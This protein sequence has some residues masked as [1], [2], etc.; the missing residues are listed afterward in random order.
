MPNE[1]LGN[2][3]QRSGADFLFFQGLADD[4]FIYSSANLLQ[5]AGVGVSEFKLMIRINIFL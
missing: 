1:A 4:D 2:I 5:C 3:K